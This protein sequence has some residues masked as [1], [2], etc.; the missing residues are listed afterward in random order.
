[1]LSSEFTA[2]ITFIHLLNVL[3]SKSNLQVNFQ[4]ISKLRKGTKSSTPFQ[5]T[6]SCKDKATNQHHNCVNRQFIS[7][8]HVVAIQVITNLFKYENTFAAPSC[9]LK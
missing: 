5:R 4:T 1:M 3:L 6:L 2:N 7:T 9:K 8:K